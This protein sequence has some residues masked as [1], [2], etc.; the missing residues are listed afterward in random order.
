MTDKYFIG[1][2]LGVNREYNRLVWKWPTIL[3]TLAYYRNTYHCKKFYI[4][5]LWSRNRK[6]L[7]SGHCRKGQ[8]LQLTMVRNKLQFNFKKAPGVTKKIVKE[9]KILGV[10]N[11]LAYHGTE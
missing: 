4:T 6:C 10:T 7:K 11:T 2:Y 5:G 8:T 3:N 9:W 1:Q